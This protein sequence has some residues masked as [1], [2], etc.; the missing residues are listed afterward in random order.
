MVPSPVGGVSTHLE[1][2]WEHFEHRLLVHALLVGPEVVEPLDHPLLQVLAH[3]AGL[4]GRKI[5]HLSEAHVLLDGVHLV[6]EL[7]PRRVHVG[8]HRADVPHDRGEDQHANQEVDRDK[9][10]LQVLVT[11]LKTSSSGRGGIY[12]GRLG[13]LPDGGEGEGGPVEAV[14]VLAGQAVVVEA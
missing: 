14:D 3:L 6:P 2:I 8:D 10:I 12:L 4:D 5:L 11:G 13:G 7:G 1:L 9:N